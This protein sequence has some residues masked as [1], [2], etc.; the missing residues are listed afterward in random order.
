MGIGAKSDQ[1]EQIQVFDGVICGTSD[2]VQ[3]DRRI[4]VRS[5]MGCVHCRST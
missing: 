4:D 1:N 3:V 2:T 5:G